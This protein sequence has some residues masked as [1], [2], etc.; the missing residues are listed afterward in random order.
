MS[1]FM[2][3]ANKTIQDKLKKLLE[4]KHL[5][6]S[7]SFSRDEMEKIIRTESNIQKVNLEVTSVLNGHWT[8]FN[9]LQIDNVYNIFSDSS[10]APNTRRIESKQHQRNI[11]LELRIVGIRAYCGICKEL[12]PMN[13]M[14]AAE[15]LSSI[16]TYSLTPDR[17]KKD[18][19]VYT[20]SF[21]CQN[22]RDGMEVFMVARKGGKL[23]LVGRTPMEQIQII[24]AIPKKQMGYYSSAIIAFN[25]GQVLPALFMLRTFIEQFVRAE[26]SEEHQESE[27]NMEQLFDQYKAKC[28][29]GFNERHP[30]LYVVYGKLSAAM[31]T[32][33][34]S[35]RL[36]GKCRDDIETHFKGRQHYLSTPMGLYK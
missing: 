14:Q 24:D 8:I 11:P 25:S 35:E 1:N 26:V 34:A 7:V 16:H 15:L 3:L 18:Q 10:L 6:Q 22:C 19:S 12:V 2:E 21:Q 4:T 27:N 13:L 23:T 33:N 36:F 28:L 9:P 31:H 5:Y 30:P 17:Q 29:D 20:F 32:A